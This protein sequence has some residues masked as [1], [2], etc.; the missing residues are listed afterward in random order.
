MLTYFYAHINI[1]NANRK[2]HSG[3]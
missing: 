2:G 3:V 1:R